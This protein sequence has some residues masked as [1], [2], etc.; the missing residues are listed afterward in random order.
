MEG[1]K[2]DGCFDWNFE[3]IYA[4]YILL[5][6]FNDLFLLIV[7]FTLGKQRFALATCQQKPFIASE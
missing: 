3:K 6:A 7:V 5:A 1:D 2:S 4:T